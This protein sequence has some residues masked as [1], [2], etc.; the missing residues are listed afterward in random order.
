VQT[1][2]SIVEGQTS[3]RKVQAGRFTPFAGLALFM[4]ALGVYGLLSFVV[5]SRMRELGVRRRQL[6]KLRPT[7]VAGCVNPVDHQSVPPRCGQKDQSTQIGQSR[8]PSWQRRHASQAEL[9]SLTLYR[10]RRGFRFLRG[11]ELWNRKS[12]VRRRADIDRRYK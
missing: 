11:G 10:A 3:G 5:T 2:G 9:E 6:V 7:V 12:K 1:L 4:A 8:R